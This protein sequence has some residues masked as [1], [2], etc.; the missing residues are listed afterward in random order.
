VLPGKVRARLAIEA[1]ATLSWWKYVGTEGRVIGLDRFGA[2][3]KGP[4]VMA[5]FGFT[6]EHIRLEI[7]ELL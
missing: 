7:E 1:G 5:H 3:G 4:E 6:A 2:S